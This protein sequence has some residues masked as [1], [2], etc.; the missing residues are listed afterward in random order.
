[1]ILDQ[2]TGSGSP[3][4][5]HLSHQ[6]WH[7]LEPEYRFRFAPVGTFSLLAHQGDKRGATL[8]HK[9]ITPMPDGVIGLWSDSCLH[10]HTGMF[11]DSRALA[12]PKRP[13]MMPET[14][15]SPEGDQ[16]SQEAY[17]LWRYPLAPKS[18]T[19]RSRTPS[20]SPSIA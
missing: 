20:S 14:S 8:P 7:D 6:G 5:A 10:V 13:R 11:T 18:P 9:P 16:D 3:P 2:R 15:I 17:E 1:M 19:V 4:L 12:F